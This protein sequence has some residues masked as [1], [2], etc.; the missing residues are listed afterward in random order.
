MDA[1]ESYKELKT[2]FQIDNEVIDE[3]NGINHG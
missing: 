2:L 1:L 3:V